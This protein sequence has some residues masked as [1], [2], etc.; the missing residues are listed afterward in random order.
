MLCVF[1]SSVLVFVGEE[2]KKFD[3]T[4]AVTAHVRTSARPAEPTVSLLPLYVQC[5]IRSCSVADPGRGV[6]GAR[7]PL[8]KKKKKRERER[9]RERER[10]RE[11]EKKH[12][13]LVHDELKRDPYED[14][15]EEVEGRVQESLTENQ[16]VKE[17]IGHGRVD[18]EAGN[19]TSR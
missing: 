4:T 6:R 17:H 9:E 18:I 12:V 15:D 1:F 14:A 11:R 19:V 13:D 5:V 2:R 7:Y 16:K 8:K 3:L 10:G